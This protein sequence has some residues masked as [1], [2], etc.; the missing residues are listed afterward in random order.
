MRVKTYPRTS[1]DRVLGR[2]FSAVGYR[3]GL[4]ETTD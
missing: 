2:A 1:A 4:N 3:E